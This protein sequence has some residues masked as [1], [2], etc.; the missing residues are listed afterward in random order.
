VEFCT[1]LI[2]YVAARGSTRGPLEW[3]AVPILQ[4]PRL[5]S[6]ARG[7]SSRDSRDAYRVGMAARSGGPLA[8]LRLAVQGYGILL[9]LAVYK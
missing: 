8:V 6:L 3:A 7:V 2:F 4:V 1:E 9:T 5:T